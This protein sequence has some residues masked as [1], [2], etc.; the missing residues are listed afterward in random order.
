MFDEGVLIENRHKGVFKVGTTHDVGP[1][2]GWSPR[3][4]LLPGREGANMTGC[5]FVLLLHAHILEIGNVG[6]VEQLGKRPLKLG[7]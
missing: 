4:R 7:I 6:N 2:K 5:Q 1:I 3:M